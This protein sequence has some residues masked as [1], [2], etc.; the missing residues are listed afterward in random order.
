MG[1]RPTKCEQLWTRCFV[2]GGSTEAGPL[3]SSTLRTS[4]LASPLL[5]ECP[6]SVLFP[7]GCHS[8]MPRSFVRVRGPTGLSPPQH[9]P[10]HTNTQAHAQAAFSR[11]AWASTSPNLLPLTLPSPSHKRLD[12][13]LAWWPPGGSAQARR[14]PVHTWSGCCHWRPYREQKS[15]LCWGASLAGTNRSPEKG[16]RAEGREDPGGWC[17]WRPAWVCPCLQWHRLKGHGLGFLK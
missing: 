13:P 15:S 14:H 4:P 17:R 2:S 9:V 6:G 16:E 7:R 5:A 1:S 12:L 8:H 3:T 11:A 10:I